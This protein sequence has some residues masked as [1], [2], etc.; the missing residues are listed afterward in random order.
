VANPM[1]R[2]WQTVVGARRRRSFTAI[3]FLPQ[4]AGAAGFFDFTQV[5]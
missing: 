3:V 5:P 1:I 4:P 2:Q